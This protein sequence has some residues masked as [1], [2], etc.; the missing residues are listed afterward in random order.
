MDKGY[1]FIVIASKD[2]I[3]IKL[4]KFI[5]SLLHAPSNKEQVMTFL[6]D[7]DDE[8]HAQ[9]FLTDDNDSIC[10]F[11]VQS[12]VNMYDAQPE[13]FSKIGLLYLYDKEVLSEERGPFRKLLTPIFERMCTETSRNI[14]VFALCKESNPSPQQKSHQL[15]T[16]YSNFVKYDGMN[17]AFIFVVNCNH[18]YMSL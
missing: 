10:I 1:K 15:A 14:P 4:W 16:H 3:A 18:Y 6:N 2:E 13:E 5:I 17:Y 12:F 8:K 11:N 7:G 9:N